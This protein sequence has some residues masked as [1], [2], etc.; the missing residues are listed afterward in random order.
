MKPIS[1]LDDIIGDRTCEMQWDIRTEI[2]EVSDN[3]VY[4]D[5]FKRMTLVDVYVFTELHSSD[6]VW[7][8]MKETM[9]KE[10]GQS[11]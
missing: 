4:R 3:A 5:M 2:D 9:R 10:F 7:D 8:S 6:E 1:Y 11:K